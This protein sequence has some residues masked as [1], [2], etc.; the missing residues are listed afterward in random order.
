MATLSM[1]LVLNLSLSMAKAETPNLQDM[2]ATASTFPNI[3]TIHIAY[4]GETIWAKAYNGANV[5]DVANIKSAS[6]SVMSAL[7]GIAHR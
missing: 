2:D 7:I 3:K 1:L 4:Q 6:K 5:N